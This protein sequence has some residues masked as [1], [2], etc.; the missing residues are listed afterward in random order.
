REAGG[1]RGDRPADPAGPPVHQ[2][3][4]GSV[5]P[6]ELEIRSR[7]NT[8]LAL[9]VLAV[10]LSVAAY[11]LVT[12]GKT[13]RKPPG[14]GGFVAVIAV[15][16]LLAHVVAGRLAPGSDPALLPTAAVLAGLGYAMI[17]RLA[18]SLAGQQ[19]A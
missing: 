9:T 15:S 17:Y 6:V 5:T 14:V 13:G 8:Q 11:V 12:L 2:L 16:Y 1:R 4:S 19:L 7:R 10:I 3:R 18:P